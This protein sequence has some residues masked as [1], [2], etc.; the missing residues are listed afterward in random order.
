MEQPNLKGEA[1]DQAI[2]AQPFE[3]VTKDSIEAKIAKVDYLVLPDSTVTLC[4]ITLKNGYSVRG[5]SACVDP[6]NFNVE[7]GKSLAYKQAF[8]KLWPLEGYL[9]AERRTVSRRDIAANELQILI[10]VAENNAPIHEK[11]GNHAQAQLCRERAEALKAT[12]NVL[13]A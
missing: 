11:E 4:N 1:L 3:K 9:L 8:D 13:L 6:R 7:I 12:M 10:D 5:E 2:A